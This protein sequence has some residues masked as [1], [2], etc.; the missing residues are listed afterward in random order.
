MS[1]KKEYAFPIPDGDGCGL[2]KLEYVSCAV[3]CAVISN[4]KLVTATEQDDA[5][6]DLFDHSIDIADFAVAQAKVLL[7]AITE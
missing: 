1:L 3:L 2:T 6:Y 5:F 4:P 7:G